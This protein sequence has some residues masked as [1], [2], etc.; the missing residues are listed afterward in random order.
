MNLELEIKPEK[1]VYQRCISY[2]TLHLNFFAA[3]LMYLIYCY[4]FNSRKMLK[5]VS[6]CRNY[7]IHSFKIGITETSCTGR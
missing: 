3:L 5:Q 7:V 4:I 1:S 2:V 6:D